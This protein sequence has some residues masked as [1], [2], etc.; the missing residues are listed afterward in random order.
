MDNAIPCTADNDI[1]HQ[2]SPSQQVVS[3]PEGEV[4]ML[5]DRTISGAFEVYRVGALC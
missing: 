5:Q 4:P 2:T 3:N 1:V